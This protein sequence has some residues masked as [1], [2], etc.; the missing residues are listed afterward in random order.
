MSNKTK[1]ATPTKTVVKPHGTKRNNVKAKP[2]P[3]P[4][5]GSAACNVCMTG[6]CSNCTSRD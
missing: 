3:T 5:W 4:S 6:A 2:S 1:P